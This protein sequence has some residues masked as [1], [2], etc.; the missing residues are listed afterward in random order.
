MWCLAVELWLFSAEVGWNFAPD[1]G[2]PLQYA[3]V[4]GVC[5]QPRFGAVYQ[6]EDGFVFGY[7]LQ[8]CFAGACA[9]PCLCGDAVGIDDWHVQSSLFYQ[10]EC[11]HDGQKFA[12]IV[13]SLFEWSEVE[14]LLSRVGH[15]AAVL[16]HAGVAA[17][18]RIDSDAIGDWC[19]HEVVG[20]RLW[21]GS[22]VFHHVPI[23]LCERHAC[24]IFG[25]ERLVLCAFEAIDLFFA[26]FPRVE[27]ACFA[28]FPHDVIFLFFRHIFAIYSRAICSASFRFEA[29]WNFS[30]LR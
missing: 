24:G 5:V 19:C 29:K 13:G 28:A 16:H 8:F 20:S 10:S 22:V 2:V 26:R 17:A 7:G 27:D 18:R 1:F 12:D 4:E 21:V 14:H 25:G 9:H 6:F 11:V 23:V 30:P 15:H 3:C